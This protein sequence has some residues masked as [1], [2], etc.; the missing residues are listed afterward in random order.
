MS[1]RVCNI[2]KNFAGE[3][4]KAPREFTAHE[5]LQNLN[6]S[7]IRANNPNS[8]VVTD[9]DP[10]AVIS[11]VDLDDDDVEEMSSPSSASEVPPPY[12]EVARARRAETEELRLR[13]HHHFS[14]LLSSLITKHTHPDAPPTTI[15]TKNSTPSCL[16][17]TSA[18]VRVSDSMA[19]LVAAKRPN[20]L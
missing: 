19:A 12:L 18:H 3:K 11:E 1:E 7:P 13:V 2:P 5:R 15:T 14:L 16:P 17:K 10:D 4:D 20:E 9:V 6:S 8:F